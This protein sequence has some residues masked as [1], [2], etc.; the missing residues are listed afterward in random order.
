MVYDHGSRHTRVHLEI[1]GQDRVT[2][3]DVPAE[4]PQSDADRELIAGLARRFPALSAERIYDRIC[5]HGRRDITLA[6]VNYV[7]ADP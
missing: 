4:P 2:P 3:L 7:L 6:A 1:T 5:R